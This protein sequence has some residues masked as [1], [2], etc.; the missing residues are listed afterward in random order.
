MSLNQ[1]NISKLKKNIRFSCQ[2]W[3]F[4]FLFFFFEI[5]LG[6]GFRAFILVT[7]SLWGET[8]FKSRKQFIN[9]FRGWD[10]VMGFE[11]GGVGG[12]MIQSQTSPD[13]RFVEVAGLQQHE[14]RTNIS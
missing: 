5:L 14:T 1:V 13:F 7:F 10:G 3:L 8:G 2:G 9:R 12:D 11:R 4:L 6:F